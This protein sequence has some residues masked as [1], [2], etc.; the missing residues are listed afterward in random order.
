MERIKEN[1]VERIEYG[2]DRIEENEG[3]RRGLNMGKED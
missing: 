2:L 3:G 1:E